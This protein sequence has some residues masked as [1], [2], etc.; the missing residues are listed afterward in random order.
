LRGI[1][2]A[3]LGFFYPTLLPM[4]SAA[5]IWMFFFTPNYGLFN[6]F[7]RLFGYSGPENWTGNPHLALLAVMIVAIWKNA[8]FYMLFYLAG[9]QNLPADVYEA[10]AL[11]GATWWQSLWRITFP[12]LRRTTVFVTTV[13]VI[14]AFRT[15]DHVFVLTGGGPSNASNVLL[16]YLWEQRFQFQN[17]GKAAAITVI[18]VAVLL[19][20]TITNFVVS[21]RGEA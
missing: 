17:V 15:V 20:F 5:T 19:I 6:T 9:L 14:D 8:G 2:W 3:R 18:F 7:L 1:G 4:V 12:L 21:E 13:A 10:A 11:D 16:F